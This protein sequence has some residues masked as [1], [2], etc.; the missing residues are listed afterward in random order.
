MKA[1]AL[2]GLL[3]GLALVTL[4]V[5]TNGA[6]EIWHSIATLGWAG[7]A[8]VVAFHL[9][10]IALMGIAWWLLGR[11]RAPWPHFVWG[12]LI[13]DSASEALP[14]SQ[15]GGYVVGA[16]AM[17]LTGL[18]SA[19][20]A[21]STVV[22]VTVE[23][24]A[25]LA[26]TLIGLALLH[27]LRPD[28]V[29]VEPV[30]V[31][32]AAMVLLVMVFFFVQATGAGAVERIGSRV[33][34]QLLGRAIAGSGAVQQEIH[35]I[36]ARPAA[37]SAA[38]LVHLCAWVL[39]GVETW[40]TLRLMG[41]PISLSAALVIDSLLYG[42]RSVAF[43]VPNAFGVQEGGMVFLGSLFGV[44]PD[45]ALALSFIKRG[46]DLLIGVPA[47]LAWQVLEG[48]RAWGS[49]TVDAENAPAQ[50]TPR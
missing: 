48:R 11:G 13:R 2:F 39:S 24:V 7:L 50:P 22:D 32:V 19:F 27:R 8:I 20:A 37:L 35:Q 5:L 28:N 9:G 44:L 1:M 3:G 29:I 46:R 10:L 31:G 12:R 4:L 16:R 41:V 18:S 45:T 33:A 49:M 42:M 23:L 17:A 15:I 36:H 47:L 21:G 38:L 30:L 43:M 6:G 14:L 25:Q 26:Y 40:L 34:G